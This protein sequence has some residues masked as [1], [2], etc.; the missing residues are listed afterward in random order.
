MVWCGVHVRLMDGHTHEDQDTQF[1]AQSAG[2][3]YCVCPAQPPRYKPAQ[4]AF[5]KALDMEPVKTGLAQPWFP[6]LHIQ[7]HDLKTH[8]HGPS[9]LTPV[10]KGHG[11]PG[12]SVDAA[13]AF[14]LDWAPGLADEFTF[15][16]SGTLSSHFFFFLFV[17]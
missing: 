4:E 13:H 8:L 11:Q 14:I 16:P 6:R 17:F 2:P 1:T 7:T 9:C 10:L 12:C 15:G 3:T 5:N